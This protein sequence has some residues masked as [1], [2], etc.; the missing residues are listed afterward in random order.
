MFINI[1]VLLQWAAYKIWS[2]DKLCIQ[3]ILKGIDVQESNYCTSRAIMFGFLTRHPCLAHCILWNTQVETVMAAFFVHVHCPAFTVTQYTSLD[4][5]KLDSSDWSR[6]HSL[7]ASRNRLLET[8]PS[9]GIHQ[10]LPGSYLQYWC[11]C[12]CWHSRL[13]KFFLFR[14][15]ILVSICLEADQLLETK[16]CV[17]HQNGISEFHRPG[18]N[19]M[20]FSFCSKAEKLGVGPWVL[21]HSIIKCSTIHIAQTIIPIPAATFITFW[22]VIG[23]SNWTPH[24]THLGRPF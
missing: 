11:L 21:M 14:L 18:Y 17:R 9:R 3:N 12:H 6:R 24:L 10:W 15:I 5:G 19:L 2:C 1:P 23:M 20:Q 22:Q 8:I 16:Q 7:S 13:Y 4:L